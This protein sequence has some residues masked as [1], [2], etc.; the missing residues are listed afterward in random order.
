MSP[1]IIISEEVNMA[2]Q[3]LIKIKNIEFVLTTETLLV[4]LEILIE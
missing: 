1:N 2:I 3:E 4:G